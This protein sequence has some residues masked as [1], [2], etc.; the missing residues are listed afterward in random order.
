MNC[1][2][3]EQEFMI[4]NQ[5]KEFYKRIEVTEPTHCHDC[6]E[7][8]R[9][10]WRNERSLYARQCDC[11]KK[12]IIS[13]YDKDVKFSVFCP[14]CWWSD[15]HD[16]NKFAREFDFNRPFFDQFQELENQVPHISVMNR[17][18]ENSEYVND[19][20]ACKNC[21]LLFG[22]DYNED[23]MYGE[24]SLKQKNCLDYSFCGMCEDCYE[25]IDNAFCYNSHFCQFSD[26]MTDC[27]FCYDCSSLQNCFGCTGLHHK[28]YYIF[29]KAYTEQEYNLK[30]K[31]FSLQTVTGLERAKKEYF[32]VLLKYPRKYA[33]AIKSSNSTGD[34]LVNCEDSQYAFTARESKNCKYIYNSFEL[35]D[36]YDT[37]MSGIDSSELLYETQTCCNK[38]HSVMFGLFCWYCSDAVYSQYCFNSQD[39][40]GCYGLKKA[41]NFIFNK[42]YEN[43]NEYEAMRNKI[44]EHMI[45]TGEY[46]EFFPISNSPFGYNETQ[47]QIFY[48]LTK[49]QAIQKNW[50]WK[51]KIKKEINSALPVCTACGENFK[52]I[53][54]EQKFYDDKKLPAPIKC[55]TC[56]Y[57]DR[58]SL[59][60]PRKLFYRQCM[61]EL[62][63]HDHEGRCRNEFETTYAPD[64]PET[65]YCER[66]YQK[67]IY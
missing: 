24:Y 66:C 25:S 35:K 19:A 67:E 41:R 14:D 11:C 33:S 36:S 15:K 1:Q 27:W 17:R 43:R 64:R 28:Q 50:P 44:I 51:D 7:E 59:K 30:I 39:I 56:R 58:L 5:D 46:G 49:E 20:N 10:A 54:K 62:S 31:E 13:V 65:V 60:N 52:I 22:C 55:A 18:A 61:C 21:Y 37:S 40:F 38:V 16:P 48:P 3:C 29:N 26:Q 6:R 63:G 34:V 32:E 57:K 53:P 2:N 9:E 4:T 12:S 47:A 45:S 23:C 42:E 8:R